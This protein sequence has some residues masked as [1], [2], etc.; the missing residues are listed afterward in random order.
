[1]AP[2]IIKLKDITKSI[3]SIPKD[4]LRSTLVFFLLLRISFMEEY[5]IIRVR[6]VLI[7]PI[8]KRDMLR[9]VANLSR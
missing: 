8:V 4:I 1:M 7:R 3:I 2:T 9:G 6:G 5:R